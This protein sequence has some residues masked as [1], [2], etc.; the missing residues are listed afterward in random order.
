MA[1]PAAGAGLA[2]R[3][4]KC[5][6]CHSGAGMSAPAA[7]TGYR[8][9]T[10][11]VSAL[12]RSVHTSIRCSECHADITSAPHK[13]STQRVNCE[14][15]HRPGNAKGAPS[16]TLRGNYHDSIHAKVL[17]A[18]RL[19]AALCQDCHGY[20]DIVPV[21]SP[22]S[23][24]NRANVPNT[25]GR[26][27]SEKPAQTPRGAPPAIFA[28]YE[29]SVHG[30]AWAQGNNNAAV[31]TDCHGVHDI[32]APTQEQSRVARPRIPETCAKC[33]PRI[34]QDYAGSIHG[35]KWR[36]GVAES[37]V[38]TDCHGEHTIL[39]P[40]DPDSSVYPSHVSRTCAACHERYYIQRKFGIPARR[41][42]TY[43]QSYHGISV[44]YGDIRAANCAS[45]HGAHG[46]LPSSDPRSGTNPNNI[47]RTCGQCHPGAG[48]KWASGRIHLLPSRQQDVAVYYTRKAYQIF[49]AGLISAFCAYIVLDLA[50]HVRQS[51]RRRRE[52]PP[53]DQERAE[54]AERR[55]V[56]WT[57]NQRLQ[58][59][60]LML[61]FTVLM[62]TGMVLRYHE[63]PV[64][65]AVMVVLGGI[66]A[67]ALVHRIAA[68]ALMALSGY[69]VLYVFLTEHGR[70][71]FLLL[72][73]KLQDAKDAMG[74]LA[75]Y[76]GFRKDEPPFGRFNF[77]EKFEY[78]SVAWG[79]VVMILSGLVLWF[80]ETA[81]MVLPKWALDVADSVHGYEAVLAFLAIIIWHFY[82]VHL[83][84]EAF[85]MSWVW[86]DGRI[87][88]DQLKKHH[89]L[90]YQDMAR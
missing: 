45:C 19:P 11:D 89:P 73:P 39:P 5:L 71:D 76:L 74:M 3:E 26:C 27:H 31:C 4:A 85:P 43:M 9:L 16:P 44:Q 83:N 58:H 15:C 41:L 84:P 80:K 79:S 66:E 70:T 32:K 37:P 22:K 10:V 20:H 52:R 65:R 35:E 68:G 56:R 1:S 38:C 28:L 2:E 81:L 25:C 69:H 29:N 23:R 86:L 90:E 63:S 60:L 36:Q 30:K 77:I 17:T 88:E 59:G 50:I 42:A 12:E 33:H 21:R 14:R 87:S 57:L 24:V 67:R 75:Y 48:K 72:V 82:H 61:S 49:I 51:R 7:E 54:A 62:I 78:L 8:S 64:S 53:P 47:P 6:A 40:T 34:Y 46:I 55:F 18:Q 13:P